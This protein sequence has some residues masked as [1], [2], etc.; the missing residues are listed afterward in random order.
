MSRSKT[1]LWI[2]VAAV[3]VLVA[4]LVLRPHIWRAKFTTLQGAVVRLSSDPA[5]QS[6]VADVAVTASR[7]AVT[8]SART[9]ASGYFKIVFPQVIWPGQTVEFT[10]RNPNYHPLDLSLKMAF[11]STPRRL[12][13][14]PLK[15]LAQQL[16]SAS[17][18]PPIRV[19]NIRVRYTVNSRQED[20]IGSV[21]RTFTVANQGNIPCRHRGPCSPDGAWKASLGSIS[22]D[23]GPGSTYENVRASCIAGPCPFTR[24]DPSGFSHGGRKITAAALNWSN[25]ATFL[26][27]AEVFHSYIAS[28]VRESYPVIYARTLNFTLPPTQEGVTIEAELNGAP[29][30]FP[31]G[32]D[33]YLSWA[34]CMARNSS[35]TEKS[36]T[37]QCELKP[38]YTF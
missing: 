17:S 16:L 2:V 9:D 21:A 36:T 24:I 15:P 23:A 34:T 25:T 12:I 7:G 14:A 20:N 30:I 29:M 26:V 31:L 1:I 37:Y 35:E 38:G 22:L 11:R 5:K 33:L 8:A 13:V 18:T 28:N 6:P 32:P 27:E 3:A 4:V 10:F 19:M